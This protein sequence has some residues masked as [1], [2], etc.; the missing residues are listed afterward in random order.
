M[1]R[2]CRVAE[3]RCGPR[4]IAPQHGPAILR[5]TPAQAGMTAED[6][7]NQQVDPDILAFIALLGVLML[8]V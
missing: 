4:D 3:T 2:N 5:G 1:Q 6:I 7:M 8:L